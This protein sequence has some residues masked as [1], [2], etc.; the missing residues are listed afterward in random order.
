MHP[1]TAPTNPV[2]GLGAPAARGTTKPPDADPGVGSEFVD[3]PDPSADADE[4]DVSAAWRRAIDLLVEYIGHERGLREN[5]VQAY[6]RDAEH[7]ARIFTGWGIDRPDEVGLSSLRR[8][9]ARL[10]AE[11]FARSTAARRASTLRTWFSVLARR[12]IIAEDPALLLA[13]P[14]QSRHLPRVLRVDQIERLLAAADTS[15]PVGLRDRAL[16]ELLYA[17]GARVA[18]ACGLDLS[19]IEAQ[20]ALVRLEGKGGKARLVPLGEPAQDAI[21]RYLE[22]GRGAL[23]VGGGSDALLLNTRGGRLGPRDA[24]TAVRRAAINAGL[25]PITPHTL[26]HSYATHLLE[27][28]AD[29]RQVQE[30]LGHASL[31]TTQRYTHLSRGRLREIH[32]SAHPRAR[33]NAR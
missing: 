13:T 2:D 33:R 30:L 29:M 1:D 8:Y 28:G 12:E 3:V 27:R 18:E 11:G 15:T 26:R 23:A 22:A 17:T 5:T 19:A 10:H 14:R 24:R 4:D 16:L 25:G 21:A 9:L 6:R 7:A 32:T 31:A 20:D